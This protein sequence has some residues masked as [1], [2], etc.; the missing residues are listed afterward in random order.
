MNVGHILTRTAKN[1][2]D[3]EGLVV[4][5]QR[6]T[7]KEINERVNQLANSLLGQGLNK[8]DRVGLLFYN[9]LAYF[10]SY[11]ALY[12]AGLVW[13]RLNYRLSVSELTN[14]MLDSQASA[15]LHGPEFGKVADEICES[16]SGVKM[17]IHQGEGPGLG[18]EDPFS[19]SSKKEPS[20]E[21]NEEDL[22]DIWYTSGT[23]GEPKGIMI[24]HR[25]IL[26][27][28]QF[29]LSDV[30][31]I[32]EDNK[33]LTV[34]ALSHA[35]SVRVLPFILRGALNVLLRAFD[36]SE[37]FKTIGK[38]KIT[39]ISTVPTMLLALMDHPE[40]GNYDLSSLKTITYAGA[41]TPVERIKEAVNIF[42][43]ILDQS[44]GQ[45]E[46]II[47]ITHL[48]KHEHITN[49]DPEREKH[50]ESVGRE[51]PGVQIKVVNE[52]HKQ[53]APG[54]IG[55]L[56]T[57]SDLVMKGYWNRPEQT[58]E[59]LKD[60]WLYTG[61]LGYQDKK[62]YL[63]LMDRKH[64][65]IITGG[66]NVYPREVE[67]VLAQHKAVAEGS[68]FG[69]PDSKWGEAVTAAVTLRSGADATEQELIEFCKS[70]I[71]SYKSPKKVHILDTL[72]KN[73]YGKILQRELKKR[74]SS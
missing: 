56:I 54:E 27:C 23:T 7:F 4:D 70:K 15:I 73:A 29:L 51:Y 25:N 39:D 17:R 11:L 30:Y 28:V 5:G 35:G 55:E 65:K 66:L 45:A 6:L 32:T 62:G 68:V 60:G 38:E 74:F 14:M 43:P 8:G 2:P 20:V 9:S 44:F 41:P 50:L 42:G 13:V 49:N 16:I 47:T 3:R 52:K 40:R 18:Y 10:E 36:P 72:P 34:G 59:A 1:F 37:I 61:D 53:C 31:W 12:K 26:T 69:I 19:S 48:P 21:V 22:S 58:A 63:Y 24:T 57:K 67:E 46:S 71:A 33:L 64:G